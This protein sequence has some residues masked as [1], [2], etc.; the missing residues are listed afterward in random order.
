MDLNQ[1]VGGF[2]D[3]FEDIDPNE[4]GADTKFQELDEWDSLA[5]LNIIAFVKTTYGKGVTGRE[6][7]GCTTVKD[8]FDLVASK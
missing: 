8:L 7:R 3:L 4:V 5:A 1:F 2:A 6:I